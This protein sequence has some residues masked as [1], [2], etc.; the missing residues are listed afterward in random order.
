MLGD[1]FYI[2]KPTSETDQHRLLA[3]FH[4]LKS[5]VEFLAERF[6]SQEEIF[7]AISQNKVFIITGR[8]IELSTAVKIYSGEF[9]SKPSIKLSEERCQKCG[10]LISSPSSFCEDRGQTHPK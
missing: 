6:G 7:D 3:T 8:E 1:K 10:E 2:F 5:V 4:D 9:S